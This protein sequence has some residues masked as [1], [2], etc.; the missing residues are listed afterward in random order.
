MNN[1]MKKILHIAIISI[2]AF[3]LTS[4]SEWLDVNK[5]PDSP[6]NLSASVSARLPWLQHAYGYAYGNAAVTVAPAIGHM[7]SRSSYAAY[8]D[9]SPGTNAGPTTPYQQWFVDGACNVKDLVDKATKEEAW[10]YVGAARV[11]EAMGYVL[12]ADI[13]GEMPFTEACGESL[14]PAYDNGKTIYEGCLAKLDEALEMFAKT[15]PLTATKLVDG[16]NW[17]G[18]DVQKWIKLCHGLKARWLNNMSKKSIYD[19]TK[20]LAELAQGPAS[21][22]ESTII[23]H[24]NAVDD[25]EGDPLIGDPL[26]TSFAFDVA[27]WGTWGRINLWYMNIL[28]NSYTGG[29]KDIDPRLDKL[30]PSC[31]RWKDLNNDGV[32]EKYWDRTKGVDLINGTVRVESSSAPLDNKF[33]TKTK[34]WSVITEDTRRKGDTAYLQINSLC[35]AIS[36]AGYDGNSTKTWPDGTV[37]TTGTFYTRPEAPT[38]IITYHEMCFIKAEVLFRQGDKGGALVAYQNGIKAHIKHMQDKLTSYGEDKQNIGRNPM[39]QAEIDAFLASPTVTGEITMSKIMLQKFIAMSFTVQ[40]WNDMRRFDYS[41]PGKYGVVYTD[42]DRP[43]AFKNSA[44]NTQYYPGN[45][46]TDP[47]YWFR[48]FRHCSHESN[49][50]NTQL[51]LSNPKAYAP[52]LLS[53]PVWWDTAE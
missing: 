37:L 14:T 29:T 44:S 51:L 9:Y 32:K 40:N 27:A 49:Y 42:F 2:L 21:N 16:D 11:V 17:N 5:N 8:Q 20:V 10:Y 6:T 33:D 35:A 22:A 38:D 46:K 41:A 28:T 50:N 19:P 3:N 39:N 30:V 7:A 15:Q 23:N 53:I 24:V 18:G 25:M 34:K 26:R 31:E 36:G 47:D 43:A 4:C 12:M 48:R 52:E 13:Y 1:I 45:S